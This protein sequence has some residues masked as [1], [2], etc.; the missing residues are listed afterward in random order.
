MARTLNSRPGMQ[1][2]AGRMPGPHQAKE[3][4]KNEPSTGRALQLRLSSSSVASLRRDRFKLSPSVSRAASSAQRAPE[5]GLPPI[6]QR[7]ANASGRRPHNPQKTVSEASPLPAVTRSRPMVHASSATRLVGIARGWF[8]VMRRAPSRAASPPRSPAATGHQ[9]HGQVCVPGSRGSA[10]GLQR[11]R[12]Q[13]RQECVDG[14]PDASVRPFQPQAISGKGSV[15]DARREREETPPKKA[16]LLAARAD[17]A[18]RTRAGFTYSWP[19]S[20]CLAT[21]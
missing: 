14:R 12:C 1:L 17:G 6:R 13:V 8:S 18:G 19:S 21:W 20:N 16:Y 7:R 15:R 3:S 4:G 5:G 11:P 9:H 10:P 2:Q